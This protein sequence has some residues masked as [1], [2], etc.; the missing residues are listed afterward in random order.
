MIEVHGSHNGWH[1]TEAKPLT[2]SIVWAATIMAPTVAHEV[3]RRRV[4][5]GED[6]T[7]LPAHPYM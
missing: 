5:G 3:P 7:T 4:T 2:I 6:R 1:V